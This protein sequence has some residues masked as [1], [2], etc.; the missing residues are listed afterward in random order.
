MSDTEHERT[1]IY[2]W[3]DPMETVTRFTSQSGLTALR[4]IVEGDKP[5]A[6][7]MQTMDFKLA[8]VSKGR[9]VF[10][11]TPAEYHYN[12]VGVVHGGMAATLLD[13]ALGIAIQSSLPAGTT[14][15]TLEIKVN[16]L[17]PMTTTTGPVR[18]EGTVVH[19][20]RR[21]AIAEGRITDAVG[22][23]YATASTTCMILQI[24]QPD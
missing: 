18:A 9:A 24:D 20:G 10:T 7:I 22:K 6:P 1:R 13:S 15:T 3:S 16:Y 5:L 19:L 12:P 14:F 8:E 17:R 11:A 21:T 2:T 23:L 4:E